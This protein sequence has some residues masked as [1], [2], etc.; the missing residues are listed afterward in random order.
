MTAS[1]IPPTIPMTIDST[2]STSV[3]CKPLRIGGENRYCPTIRQRNP[4]LVSTVLTNIAASTAITATA[5]HRPGWRTGTAL[6]GSGRPSFSIGGDTPVT[7]SA[8]DLRG[9]DRAVGHVP[10][11]EDRRVGAVVDQGLDRA[12]HRLGVLALALREGSAVRSG[13]VGVAELL[14]RTVRRVPRIGD[15]G[16]VG[17]HG[18]DP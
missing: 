12:A 5:S 13:A 14:D 11:L 10:L 4:S 9:R 8:P 17:E 3:F 2:V 15:D 7:S 6:I 16:G 18:D 1:A